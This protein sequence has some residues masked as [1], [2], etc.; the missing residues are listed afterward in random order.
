MPEWHA[1]ISRHALDAEFGCLLIRRHDDPKP[2][3][4]FAG[5]EKAHA[6]SALCRSGRLHAFIHEPEGSVS[7]ELVLEPNSCDPVP[8]G[9]PEKRKE[10][11][12]HPLGQFEIGS[13]ELTCLGGKKDI[14][15]AP[16][17]MVRSKSAMSLSISAAGVE[18][19]FQTGIGGDARVDGGLSLSRD[20]AGVGTRV[21]A[22]EAA[23]DRAL[24]A[25]TWRGLATWRYRAMGSVL[26]W[27]SSFCCKRRS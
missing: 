10:C 26:A 21:L 23:N 6:K 9:A 8:P 27:R 2:H 12:P 5:V 18:V 4:E 14:E 13:I 24:R 3:M 7:V 1:A 16:P 15:R 20:L 19:L 17:T 25:R 11:L 22:R